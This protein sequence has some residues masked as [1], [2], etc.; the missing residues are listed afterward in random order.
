[1]T[2]ATGPRGRTVVAAPAPRRR[3]AGK[4]RERAGADGS[5]ASIRPDGPAGAVRKDTDAPSCM[6]NGRPEPGSVRNPEITRPGGPAGG[7]SALH[8]TPVGGIP[9]GVASAEIIR[10]TFAPEY[11]F[12]EVSSFRPSA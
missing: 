6:N 8:A 4:G 9:A 2:G 12:I 11:G 5:A 1:M 7:R 3:M 10:L